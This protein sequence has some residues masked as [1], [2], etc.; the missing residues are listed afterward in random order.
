MSHF[1]FNARSIASPIM[2]EISNYNWAIWLDIDGK[3][4]S[5]EYYMN[6]IDT[7][8]EYV[9]KLGIK[10]VVGRDTDNGLIT[11]VTVGE[12]VFKFDFATARQRYLDQY[13]PGQKVFTPP[14]HN[15]ADLDFEIDPRFYTPEE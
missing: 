15:G 1:E 6:K 11:D 5:W 12:E 8:C 10:I 3:P 9:R 2:R 14:Q 4:N 13:H 7:Y